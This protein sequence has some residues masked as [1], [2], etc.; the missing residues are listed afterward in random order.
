M[1]SS[2]EGQARQKAAVNSY[3]DV[4]STLFGRVSIGTGLAALITAPLPRVGEAFAGISILTA[5]IST[6]GGGILHFASGG[7]RIGLGLVGLGGIATVARW[8]DER[9]F[10]TPSP[11]DTKSN[12]VKELT[13]AWPTEFVVKF[14]SRR[15]TGLIAAFAVVVVIWTDRWWRRLIVAAALPVALGAGW[16]IGLSVSFGPLW[17]MGAAIPLFF[18]IASAAYSVFGSQDI[19]SMFGPSEVSF[20]AVRKEHIVMRLNGH[21]FGHPVADVRKIHKF[22]RVT[23]I[24]YVGHKITVLPTKA[25]PHH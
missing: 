18:V 5:F 13:S 25:M 22:G 1:I 9:T 20:V 8:Q 12:M 11:M 7:C 19:Q 6:A 14:R 10:W 21:K 16:L 24:E 3:I 15:S 23:V 2:P 4:S 17:Q